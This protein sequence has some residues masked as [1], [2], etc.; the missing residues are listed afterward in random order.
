MLSL[1]PLR[2]KVKAKLR[3]AA[4]GRKQIQRI[5]RNAPATRAIAADEELAPNKTDYCEVTN[6]GGII[7][8][9]LGPKAK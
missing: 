7:G 2:A 4:A 6:L 3:R 1:F 5:S 9:R 8:A